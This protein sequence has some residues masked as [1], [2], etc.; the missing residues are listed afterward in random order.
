MSG[1]GFNIKN[2][3]FEKTKL[4]ISSQNVEAGE[5]K[6]WVQVFVES[7]DDKRLWLSIFEKYKKNYKFR[8]L[9]ALEHE[10]DD[11]KCSNGCSR[12][13]ALYKN[14]KVQ[15]GKHTILC[16]DSDYGFVSGNYGCKQKDVLEEKFVYQTFVHSKESVYINPVGIDIIL[17]RAIGEDIESEGISLLGIHSVISRVLYPYWI[18]II[19]I[20]K[21]GMEE[22]FDRYHGE[23][24]HIMSECFN[25]KN[26][27]D[28]LSTNWIDEANRNFSSFDERLDRF[29]EEQ[30]G[31]DKVD[32]MAKRL[33][34]LNINDSDCL[35][36]VRGHNIYAIM[37]KVYEDIEALFFLKKIQSIDRLN[38]TSAQK[39][40]QKRAMANKRVQVMNVILAR[41]DVCNTPF[42]KDTISELD[43][44]YT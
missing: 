42:F 14:G 2:D 12:L 11:G 44:H 7:D 33:Q 39:S 37:K 1:L 36:F 22:D 43:T 35:F 13:S 16:L 10:S 4:F 17:S 41:G 23:F 6:P 19:T 15:L 40:E 31:K 20:Y 21:H 27:K 9:S 3:Y 29:I 32:D 26:V 8:Y 18:K 28:I 5:S 24:V 38:I 34:E 25:Y 30:I